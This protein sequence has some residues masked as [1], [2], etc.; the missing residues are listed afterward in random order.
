MCGRYTLA[1]PSAELI[2]A[3]DV[4][5]LEF[6]YHPRYNIAPGQEAP[7]VAEDRRGRR[8]GLL[9]WGFV[10][11]GRGDR[12]R[13]FVN[14]RSETVAT[15][16]SFAEAFAQRRC[17][18]PADGFYEWRRAGAEGD[19]GRADAVPFWVHPVGGGLLSLAAI[20]ETWRGA[21]GE[22]HHGFAILTADANAEVR[23]IH[24]RM[25]VVIA[26]EDRGV[27]LARGASREQVES[28]LRSSP[29]GTF[30]CREVSTRVNRT[31]EDDDGLTEPVS[32]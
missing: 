14:A 29:D 16:R 5:D 2:E 1:A 27:W 6:D 22:R 25:P 28:L 8:M 3:F 31:S 20:W 23:P 21:G 12:G 32:G 4:P 18:V 7:V 11:A 9:A 10:P 15:K 17:L 24:D 13:P 19:S 26:A 30:E